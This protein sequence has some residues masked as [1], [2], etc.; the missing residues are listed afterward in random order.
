MADANTGSGLKIKVPSNINSGGYNTEGATVKNPINTYTDKGLSGSYT[1]QLFYRD[2]DTGDNANSSEVWVYIKTTWNFTVQ[3]DNSL[4]GRVE[5]VLTKVERKNIKGTPYRYAYRHMR[6]SAKNTTN[7]RWNV[8]GNANN[9]GNQ[10]VKRT[11]DPNTPISTHVD[12]VLKPG[13]KSEE[14]GVIHYRNTSMYKDYDVDTGKNIYTDDFTVGVYF[15]N[16][17]G[18]PDPD[19]EPEPEPC[20]QPEPPRVSVSSQNAE[21]DQLHAHP[22]LN[23]TQ[24]NMLN[25]D[26][27]VPDPETG[28]LPDPSPAYYFNRMDVYIRHRVGDDGEWQP[29]VL[30][31]S[32]GSITTLSINGT[33]TISYAPTTTPIYVQAYTV[34]D[35]GEQSET[36]DY[37]F[38]T[39]TPPK[40]PTFPSSSQNDTGECIDLT[41]QIA[42]NDAGRFSGGGITYYSYQIGG[43]VWTNWQQLPSWTGGSIT[44]K[45]CPYSTDI[46]VRSYS[47]G[48]YP[49]YGY[50]GDMGETVITTSDRVF[51]DIPSDGW[52][53][54]CGALM[55]LLELICQEWYAIKDGVRTIYPNEDMKRICADD[56]DDDPTLQSILSRLLR[57][58][59]ALG[60]LVCSGLED[61]LN[62]LKQASPK[63]K[64]DNAQT[65]LQ[66]DGE[67]WYGKWVET[68]DYPTENSEALVTSGGVYRAIQ[69][70]I[71]DV[72]HYVGTWNYL[73][74]KPSDLNALPEDVHIPQSGETA[75]VK[76]G[77]DGTNQTYTYNGSRWVAGEVNDF[78]EWHFPLIHVVYESHFTTDLYEI[79]IPAGSAWYWWND[80]WDQL[81][82]FGSEEIE[83]ELK[84]IHIGNAVKYEPTADA[85]K[86]GI[87][88]R[89]ASGVIIPET[90]TTDMIYFVH[91]ELDFDLPSE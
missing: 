44:I 9:I 65:V 13:E 91:D 31:G 68:D 7:W 76:E 89:G 11:V 5:N 73:V 41:V 30:A 32:G 22:I 26:S 21:S 52:W 61:D 28:E 85:L 78:S 75:M 51:E 86:F 4:K 82:A 2:S 62:F 23:W 19:P 47:V 33:Y 84:D 54:G 81:D 74:Y 1:T 12:V 25:P 16:T 20:Y 24:N 72:Y 55:Y 56:D 48:K 69:D 77:A 88:R 36:I 79:T 58:F 46:R 71:H 90:R 6:A 53:A 50:R 3:E 18:D 38:V 14:F 70:Y 64:V 34:N 35:C 67:G 42:Q 37:D 40:K 59:Q 60:C 17:F 87:L 45:C 29:W 66:H 8:V 10:G 63:D 43:G 80:N 15:Q 27:L 83:E 49:G 57:Y 39:P